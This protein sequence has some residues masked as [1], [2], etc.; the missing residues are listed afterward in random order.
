[1]PDTLGNISPLKEL[2][3]EYT[4]VSGI[5]PKSM[6][7]NQVL[8]KLSLQGLSICYP[9]CL[10]DTVGDVFS[11]GVSRCQDK[12]DLV[13]CG[14]AGLFHSQIADLNEYLLLNFESTHP[15]NNA[16][17]I[18]QIS[19]ADVLKRSN[20]SSEKIH[21][22]SFSFYAWSDRYPVFLVICSHFQCKTWTDSLPGVGNEDSYTVVSS[23]FNLTYLPRGCTDHDLFG[24]DCYGYSLD[25]E[26]YYSSGVGWECVE[27]T[28]SS[29]FADLAEEVADYGLLTEASY[30]AGRC[31][32]TGIT[33]NG[34]KVTEFSFPNL[35]LTGFV[36]EA[37][38]N[39]T[40]LVYVDVSFNHFMGTVPNSFGKLSS[41]HYLSIASNDFVGALPDSLGSL[42]LQ[43]LD[44]SYNGFTG[45]IPLSF[46]WLNYT[47][48][49]LDLSY[50]ELSGSLPDEL[51]GLASIPQLILKG[52]SFECIESCWVSH[53]SSLGIV[54]P[55]DELCG[56][57]SDEAQSEITA[58]NALFVIPIVAGSLIVFYVVNRF[59]CMSKSVQIFQENEKKRA[60]S[61]TSLP[62]HVAILSQHPCKEVI[63]LI[64]SYPAAIHYLDF[65]N[66]S[67]WDHALEMRADAD[68]ILTMLRHSMPYSRE[69]KL[70]VAADIHKYCWVQIIQI[71]SYLPVIQAILDEYGHVAHEL[72]ATEDV[73]GRPA[74]SI[75]SPA[76]QSL[77]RLRTFFY[78]RYEITSLRTPLY[79]SRT[80]I[81][82]SAVDHKVDTTSGNMVALKFFSCR[83]SFLL[84]QRTR[85][86]GQFH[87]DYVV[88]VLAV[89]DSQV[90]P[91]VST[92][93]GR[94]GFASYPDCLV[95]ELADRNLRT[96]A[97]AEFII[98]Q[99]DNDCIYNPVDAS[100][101]K[102]H[103]S[104]GNNN[105]S[106]QLKLVIVQL[107]K[108]VQHIHSKGFIHGDL[109][110]Q[111][112]VRVGQKIKLIDFDSAAAIGEGFISVDKCSTGYIPP[113]IIVVEESPAPQS[114]YLKSPH[115]AQGGPSLFA[116]YESSGAFMGSAGKFPPSISKRR[117]IQPKTKSWLSPPKSVGETYSFMYT[118]SNSKD[119]CAL[120]VSAHP[121]FDVWS[122]GVIVFLSCGG[123]TFFFEDHPDKIDCVYLI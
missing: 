62:L 104:S 74:I 84:E 19:T 67:A 9:A 113:E 8:Q 31:S 99:D 115:R 101:N 24:V 53:N 123:I 23:F 52:N 86:Q 103:V 109:K 98:I 110:P 64:E 83:E 69:S 87:M 93:C 29:G 18:V 14:L 77:L 71:Q 117:L 2:A 37:I 81:V 72:A 108:A 76:I 79:L 58:F 45:S 100:S 66:K 47:A 36:P 105:N 7:N 80:S 25:I 111:N 28:E 97:S 30:A 33:C 102:G 26:T 88:K 16:G 121:S 1:L 43:I 91:A 39:L 6:C 49:S 55:E 82:H 20:I 70:P 38:F 22:Y 40:D 11:P 50:N 41:L 34:G 35:G 89:L 17:S 116:D 63:S 122:R 44:A 119:D 75:A 90:D 42:T 48:Y 78:S 85:E 61:L 57:S 4:S 118:D 94:Y 59:L 5:I 95:L 120:L 54:K 12:T 112:V 3:L 107:L 96:I 21:S 15:W 68:V 92:E 51:C 32:W 27:P 73:Q 10:E 56:I 65:D 114:V 106:H 13:L 60:E 46:Q